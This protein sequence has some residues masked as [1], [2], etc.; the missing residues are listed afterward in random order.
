MLNK[1]IFFKFIF[2]LIS[3]FLI[4]MI[5]GC[6][7]N[8]QITNVKKKD[9]CYTENISVMNT[10]NN[11]DKIITNKTTVL[12]SENPGRIITETGLAENC[13]YFYYYI[14]LGNTMVKQRGISCK[15]FDGGYEIIPEYRGG[16]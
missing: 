8:T 2:N 6:G 10:D 5:T 4:L 11:K 9:N 3:F 12:C 14:P 16:R 15:K 7:P 13:N 1:K